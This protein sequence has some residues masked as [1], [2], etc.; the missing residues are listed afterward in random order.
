MNRSMATIGFEHE[1]EHEH[2]WEWE[3][4]WERKLRLECPTKWRRRLRF[5]AE[6]TP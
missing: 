5:C 3:W 4:E 1:H 2:E 6:F